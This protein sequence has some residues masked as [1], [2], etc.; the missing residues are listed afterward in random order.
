MLATDQLRSALDEFTG[1][2]GQP[3]IVLDRRRVS[4]LAEADRL[5]GGGDAGG[6]VDLAETAA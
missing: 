3:P 2:G 1:A 6:E 4:A 5:T